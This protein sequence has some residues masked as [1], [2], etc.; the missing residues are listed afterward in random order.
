MGYG[1]VAALCA[2]Y[3]CR[4]VG[5][6]PGVLSLAPVSSRKSRV[7]FIVSSIL[8][9]SLFTVCWN[10]LYALI[11]IAADMV[12]NTPYYVL[13]SFGSVSGIVRLFINVD[14]L[15][16]AACCYGGT[17]LVCYSASFRRMVVGGVI[18]AVVSVVAAFLVWYLYLAGFA[19]ALVV[20]LLAV[21][22]A[23]YEEL[24][25]QSE[26]LIE[27]IQVIEVIGP[28]VYL[29]VFVAGVAY[30]AIKGRRADT[31]VGR[32]TGGTPGNA[33]RGGDETTPD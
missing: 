15:C 29:A 8:A 9:C 5:V 16:V 11:G 31:C 18:F 28:A 20:L 19:N 3:A 7:F 27:V 26:L 25:V 12:V 4:A 21:R 6:R 1:V 23:P 30:V 2:S 33:G 22:G 10:L 17:M 14:G 32:E 24:S 13:R